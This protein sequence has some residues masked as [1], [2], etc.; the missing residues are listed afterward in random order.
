MKWIRTHAP[1]IGPSIYVDDSLWYHADYELSGYR[2]TT[3][4]SYDEIPA[5]A[6]TA[7]NYC[8]V[9]RPTIQ[10]HALFFRFPR[11]RLGQISRE[12]YFE[13][14]VIPMDAMIRFA[15][16]WYQD[17]YDASRDHAWRWMRGASTAY[18]PALPANG[19]LAMRIHLPLDAVPRP[20]TIT[21]IWNGHQIDRR[22]C[23]KSDIELR[24]LLPSRH[25]SANECT[26]TTDET[27]TPAADPRQFGM[28][29]ST[30]SWERA[31]GTP[32]GL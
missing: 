27:A 2:V 19:V 28:Q 5:A 3:F 32:Y 7:G 4:R 15:D 6:Y 24:Y 21:I 17:E 26:I 25:D 13:T 11:A 10:P 1:M 14:S 30:V 20:P 29:L 8:L 31:D 23:D 12:I 22:T 16:G 9:E 18:F